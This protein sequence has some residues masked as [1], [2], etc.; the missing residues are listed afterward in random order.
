[1]ATGPSGT[2]NAWYLEIW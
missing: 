2:W 1:C